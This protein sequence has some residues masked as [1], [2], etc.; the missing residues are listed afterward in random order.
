MGLRE[1]KAVK[2]RKRI[3][4]E[5]MQLFKR[6]GY[7]Q[8]T[9]EMIAGAAEIA[10]RTLY[11]YFL[12]KDQILLDSMSGSNSGYDSMAVF[13]RYAVSHPVEEALAEAVLD[14][15]KFQ[16]ENAEELLLV[17]S[18]IDQTPTARGKLWDLLYESELK[19]I[20]LLAE[21]VH[22]PE[23][24]LQLALSA[25]LALLTINSTVA[26]LWRAGGG[27]SSAVEIAKRV[28]RMFEENRVFIPRQA[29]RRSVTSK[30]R[31]K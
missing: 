23:D 4:S 14:W 22:L 30:R 3:L 26:D 10:P 8:T 12:S 29:P 21:K 7:E 16:D 18:I 9:M 19:L 28:M 5:A 11:R 25:R 6:N 27:K 17:R 24:D 20:A 31:A 15:A 1:T 2:T 13:S